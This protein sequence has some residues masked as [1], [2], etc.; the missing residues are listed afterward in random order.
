MVASVRAVDDDGL[1]PGSTL[2]WLG[3]V[4]VV[5][6]GLCMALCPSDTYKIIENLNVKSAWCQ[7][8]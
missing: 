8:K 3:S 2:V 6:G 1:P 7:K 5:D 4:S